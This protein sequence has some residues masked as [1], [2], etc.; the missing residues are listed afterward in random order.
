MKIFFY[1][2]ETLKIITLITRF[3]QPGLDFLY[4]LVKVGTFKLRRTGS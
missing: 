4:E 1:F 2:S 3:L